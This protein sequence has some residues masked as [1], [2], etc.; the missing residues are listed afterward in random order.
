MN[1]YLIIMTCPFFKMILNYQTFPI[2]ISNQIIPMNINLVYLKYWKFLRSH[3]Y[4]KSTS[5][6]CFHPITSF[7]NKQNKTGMICACILHFNA[8]S[9][10]LNIGGFV[11]CTLQSELPLFVLNVLVIFELCNLYK[12]RFKIVQLSFSKKTI[13]VINNCNFLFIIFD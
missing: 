6:A 8:I 11:A 4:T 5:R 12:Y 13:K 9:R 1:Y 10:P 7:L 2:V 3:Y